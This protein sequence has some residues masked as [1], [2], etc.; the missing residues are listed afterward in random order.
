MEDTNYKLDPEKPTDLH[1]EYSI[2]PLGIDTFNQ[3][4]LGLFFIQK[5]ISFK[6]LTN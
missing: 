3:D 2:N 4:F 1:C 5:E 6:L